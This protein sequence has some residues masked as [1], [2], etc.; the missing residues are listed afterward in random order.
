MVHL[1]PPKFS[2]MVDLMVSAIADIFAGF[3]DFQE[4]LVVLTERV[5]QPQIK[6][7]ERNARFLFACNT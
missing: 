2:A 4:G 7:F 5:H 3:R 1:G 6:Y